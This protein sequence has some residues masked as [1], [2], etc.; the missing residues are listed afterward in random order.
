M[1]TLLAKTKKFNFHLHL[2]P[3]D[4]SSDRFWLRTQSINATL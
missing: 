3:R 1:F 4:T 2:F